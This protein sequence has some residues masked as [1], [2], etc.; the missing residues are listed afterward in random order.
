MNNK[1]SNMSDADLKSLW[2]SFDV[3]SMVDGR[4]SVPTDLNQINDEMK[5]RGLDTGI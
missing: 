4:S 1:Y 3:E 5:L 2:D